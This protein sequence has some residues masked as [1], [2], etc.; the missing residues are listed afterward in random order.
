M[1]LFAYA[2]VSFFDNDPQLKTVLAEDTM[3]ALKQVFF[4]TC[5]NADKQDLEKD[6]EQFSNPQDVVQYL[7]D[8]EIGISIPVAVE[9]LSDVSI[10]APINPT[11]EEH[12]SAFS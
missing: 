2:Y 4:S 3:D 9:D 7:M 6:W 10:V 11:V 8:G 12:T 1:K 5:A